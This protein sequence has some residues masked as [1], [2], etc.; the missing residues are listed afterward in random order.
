MLRSVPRESGRRR[1]TICH[2]A[3][4]A[5]PVSRG[6]DPGVLQQPLAST[7]CS[8][9]LCPGRCSLLPTSGFSPFPSFSLLPSSLLQVFS[10]LPSFHVL[11]QWYPA[12]L[13]SRASSIGIPTVKWYRLWNSWLARPST[14][15]TGSS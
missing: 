11:S 5:A 4:S 7:C 2:V 12:S 8:V 6:V 14:S 13:V 3:A 9:I 15:C 1:H 10:Q